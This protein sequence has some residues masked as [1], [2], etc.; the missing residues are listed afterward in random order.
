VDSKTPLAAAKAIEIYIGGVIAAFGID[1]LGFA[2][3]SLLEGIRRGV[4]DAR[5]DIRDYEVA[6]TRPEQLKLQKAVH[7]RLHSLQEDILK[8]SQT[9]MFS[10][11]EVAHISAMIEQLISSVE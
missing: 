9:G 4:T 3:R 6:D 2:D 1:D 5:L 8:A 11:V 10:A 7:A